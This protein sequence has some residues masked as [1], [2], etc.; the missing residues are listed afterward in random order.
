[1]KE[2]EHL[3][4]YGRL[5]EV[6]GMETYL[7]GRMDYAKNAETATSCRGPGRAV[8][9]KSQYSGGGEKMHKYLPLWQSKR[10]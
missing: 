2:Q 7:H 10:E 8:K 9:K 6:I 3:E 4:I 1:M 5:R